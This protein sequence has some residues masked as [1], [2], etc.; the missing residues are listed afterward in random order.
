MNA[1]PAAKN[2][3]IL[4]DFRANAL[5]TSVTAGRF[6]KEYNNLC[7]AIA[8]ESINL[9]GLTKQTPDSGK[10]SD[11]LQQKIT[12]SR[13]ALTELLN[14]KNK[15]LQG[16]RSAEFY[17]DALFETTYGV[18]EAFIAPTEV[19]FMERETGKPYAL[20]SEDERKILKTKYADWSKSERSEQIHQLADM[21][22]GV[23][24]KSSQGLQDSA[25]TYQQIKEGQLK[26]FQDVINISQGKLNQMMDILRF[27]P[28][29]KL[30][31]LQK[32]ISSMSMDSLKDSAAPIKLEHSM[33]GDLTIVPDGTLSDMQAF[34]GNKN[35]VFINKVNEIGNDTSL[36]TEQQIPL[37]VEAFVENVHKELDKTAQEILKVG[38]VHPEVK[39][40]LVPTLKQTSSYCQD[41]MDIFEMEAENYSDRGDQQNADKYMKVFETLQ[42]IQQSL[43]DQV[44]KIEE[45]RYTPIVDNLKS[46]AI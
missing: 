29:D 37:M 45:L 41:L 23:A 38:Y 7:K 8:I 28:E 17:R 9:N 26:N 14:A 5:A 12:E 24:Q 44:S 43:D 40:N 11:E 19:Q 30:G 33:T 1:L 34:L 36:T 27:E 39:R 13:A 16:E 21:F 20:I 35:N 4:G 15:L 31:K 3:D 22:Y 42:E 46:F 25:V 6:L 10:P 18:S 32:V 2:R